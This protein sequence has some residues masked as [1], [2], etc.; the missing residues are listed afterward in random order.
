MYAWVVL[1]FVLLILTLSVWQRIQN[2][3]KTVEESKIT[4]SPLSLAIQDL[5]AI[6]GS[7]YLSLT[8]LV[9]FLKLNIPETIMIF[10]LT[11]DPLA[12]A[13]I[14]LAVIQPVFLSLF[15]HFKEYK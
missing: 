2:F 13:A 3:R 5:M 15:N 6:A 4:A 14:A 7:I 10:E 1:L 9:A 11:I 8:M 12:F